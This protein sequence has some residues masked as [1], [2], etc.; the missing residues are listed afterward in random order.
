MCSI[1]VC[2]DATCCRYGS[3]SDL[4]YNWVGTK[5]QRVVVR[6]GGGWVCC[7]KILPPA[8]STVHMSF[9]IFVANNALGGY[10]H[11]IKRKKSRCNEYRMDGTYV[12]IVLLQTSRHKKATKKR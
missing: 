11:V 12:Y 7:R 9:F 1:V 10:S 3:I 8:A 5:K 2:D 4:H 6:V